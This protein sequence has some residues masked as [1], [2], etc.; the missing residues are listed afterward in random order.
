MLIKINKKKFQKIIIFLSVGIIILCI[1]AII[2]QKIIET[3]PDTI[4][5]LIFELNTTYFLFGLFFMIFAIILYLF[6]PRLKKR[7]DKAGDL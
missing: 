6:F 1:E 5:F 7:I 2:Y 4:T 3:T